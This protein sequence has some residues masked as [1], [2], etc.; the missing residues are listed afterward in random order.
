MDYQLNYQTRPSV[1]EQI[2]ILFVIKFSELYLKRIAPQVN[3]KNVVYFQFRIVTMEQ[4]GFNKLN[5]HDKLELLKYMPIKQRVRFERINTTWARLLARLWMSQKQ[6]KFGNC[7]GRTPECHEFDLN[8]QCDAP[9]KIFLNVLSRCKNLKALEVNSHE[10]DESELAAQLASVLNE[11]CKKLEHLSVWPSTNLVLFELFIPT[12]KFTC[13]FPL[14]YER[15]KILYDKHSD[16]KLLTLKLIDYGE[17]EVNPMTWD[18]VDKVTV[19]YFNSSRW[20]MKFNK[21]INIKYLRVV[22]AM[23]GQIGHFHQ[24][25]NISLF[26]VTNNDLRRILKN[27]RKLVTLTLIRGANEAMSTIVE[28]GSNL[29]YLYTN[30]TG[31]ALINNHQFW[32]NLAKLTKLRS[33]SMFVDVGVRRNEMLNANGIY[34]LLKRC[35]KL[36]YFRF[37][38]NSNVADIT[39]KDEKEQIRKLVAHKSFRQLFSA[40]FKPSGITVALGQ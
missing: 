39:T 27:N 22:Y 20:D 38:C 1:N 19:E 21:L 14:S 3:S 25:E 11:N 8:D 29:R 28:F 12:T 18:L 30:F 26:D 10:F 34:L 4:F 23:S 31:G 24:L 2:V 9:V 13:L 36:K 16:E 15:L 6:L 7:Y 5:E 17:D 37:D 40:E 32:Q 35:T 33:L